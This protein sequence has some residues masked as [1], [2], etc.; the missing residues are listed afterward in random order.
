MINIKYVLRKQI[1]R[2]LIQ[3]HLLIFQY[4]AEKI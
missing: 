2:E 4:H 3:P 1:E